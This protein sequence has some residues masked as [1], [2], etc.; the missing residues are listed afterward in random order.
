M[1]R[2][3]DP[4]VTLTTDFGGGD[5]YVASMKGVILSR[6]PRAR[7]VDVTHD[8]EPG[9][10]PGAALVVE[11]ARRWFPA[12]AV[13]LVVVDPGVGTGRRALAVRSGGQFL[14][15]PDNGVLWPA[16]AADPKP[17]VHALTRPDLSLKPLSK[18][19]EGR[20]LFAPAAAYLASGKR[21]RSVGP[22]V[23]DPVRLGGFASRRR[24]GRLEGAVLRVDRFGNL[25][26]SVTARDLAEAFDGVPFP[27]LDIRVGGRTIDETAA[28][29]GLARPGVPFALMGSGDRLEIAVREASAAERLKVGRGAAVTVE[30]RG[31]R[32]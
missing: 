17:L 10:L 5:A 9:D 3:V 1:P 24:G 7:L 27:T 29:Y 21:I 19:F 26:T 18:T 28:T 30:R 23:H 25:V 31:G 20:D 16:I 14:V 32:R 22:P 6:C 13:H 8:L 12:G 15:G 4:V 11:E 2:S